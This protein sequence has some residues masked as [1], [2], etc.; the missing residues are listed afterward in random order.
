GSNAF[1]TT[2]GA[3]QPVGGDGYHSSSAFVT[4]VNPSGSALVYSTYLG[5]IGFG[6]GIAVDAD[7]NAYVT[8]GGSV[9]TTAG[10]F[11]PTGGGAFV[12]KLDPAGTELAYS[13]YLG[14][15]GYIESR[16]IALDAAGNA[17]VTGLTDSTVF[18]TTPDAFQRSWAGDLADCCRSPGCGP[19]MLCLPD[20]FLTKLN[21]SGTGLV[22]STYLGGRADDRGNRIAVDAAGNAYVSGVTQ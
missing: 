7:G 21:P 19:P 18:P 2:P 9:P 5:G 16:G 17:Y 14:S 6:S 12:A 11:Q 8:G 15:R 1:P 3:F 20:A 4:K 22:Y 13:T 10:A